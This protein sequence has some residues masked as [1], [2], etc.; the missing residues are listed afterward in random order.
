M[1]AFAMEAVFTVQ[2]HIT[3]LQGSTLDLFVFKPE[4]LVPFDLLVGPW[5]GSCHQLIQGDQM[6]AHLQ[7]VSLK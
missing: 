3:P 7:H 2:C 4:L 5:G 6:L 1:L